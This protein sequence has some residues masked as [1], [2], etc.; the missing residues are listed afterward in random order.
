[1]P[2]SC[3]KCSQ[4]LPEVETMKFRY[5][6][7]CGAE[8]AAAP[9]KLDP[10]MLTIPP[11]MSKQQSQQGAAVL[12]PQPDENVAATQSFNDQ[13]VEPRPIIK[14][15]DTPPPSSFFRTRPEIKE[16]PAPDVKQA[17]R[18]KSRKNTIIVILILLIVVILI[19]GGIFT[20]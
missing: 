12:S 2:T 1:M 8:I 6:P 18:T 14:P 17:P 15:P 4:K 7:H 5:C 16:P 11:D 3:P 20:F 13:T 9:E 10:D 19:M